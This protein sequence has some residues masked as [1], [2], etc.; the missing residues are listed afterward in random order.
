MCADAAAMAANASWKRFRLALHAVTGC[1]SPQRC[2]SE[3]HGQDACD[4]D[5]VENERFDAIDFRGAGI[6][7]EVLLPGVK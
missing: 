1:S 4:E 7:F 2:D 5:A 6:P 3:M